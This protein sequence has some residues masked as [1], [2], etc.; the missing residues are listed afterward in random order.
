[1][2]EVDISKRTKLIDEIERNLWETW[3]MFGRGPGCALHEEE[4]ALWLETPIPIVPYNGILKFQVQG[5]VDQRV[6]SIIEHFN[7]RRAQFMWIVHPTAQPP[8]LRDRL[9]KRGLKDVEPILG[10]A[11][12]L[13]DLPELPPLPEDIEVRKVADESDTCAFYQFAEWR[14]HVPDEYRDEYAAIV[15]EFRVGKP[16]SKAHMWQ[17]WRAGQPISKAGMYLGSGSAGI[18]AVVTRP[19]ARGLGLARFLTLAALHEARSSGYRLAVLHSTPMAE[20]LY[21]SL[22][23]ATIAEFRLFASEEVRV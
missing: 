11:R 15:T 4:D 7:Q 19:E 20:N 21:Q 3:S 1:M 22:G 10:M 2:P 14:W 5:N 17:A 13:T 9:Q 12:D 6:D 18:F 8:D 23:F 16:S